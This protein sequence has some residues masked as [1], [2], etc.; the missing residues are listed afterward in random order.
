MTKMTS[1]LRPGEINLD[2]IPLDWPLTPLGENK[3]PY[4]LGWQ[5]KPFTI[6]EV[7]K[8]LDSKKAAAIGLISGPVYQ[9]PYGLVWVDIDG[10]SVWNV[11]GELSGLSIEQALPKT[12]TIC[13]GR[14]GRE[15]K[16]YLVP[17]DH[18]P[19]FARNKYNWHGEGHNE[20]LEV[21][22]KKCQGVLMGHHPNTDG[23]FTKDGE[24]YEFVNN[25]PVIPDWLLNAIAKKNDCQHCFQDVWR[26][27]CHQ[28]RDRS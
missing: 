10:P 28:Y 3:N 6:E 22:W 5:G 11:I 27:F 19:Q 7:K 14:E 25:L 1:K 24:D 21:L 9:K 2:F 20:K 8:E 4:I 13:S 26:K 12:L 15:R 17:K 16:L 23:Y 18:W